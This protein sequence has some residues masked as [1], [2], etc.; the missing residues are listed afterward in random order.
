MVLNP[1]E[2]TRAI[3]TQL[4]ILRKIWNDKAAY[5]IWKAPLCE[6]ECSDNRISRSVAN[7]IQTLVF[8]AIDAPQLSLQPRSAGKL[9]ENGEIDEPRSN[10]ARFAFGVPKSVARN[11]Y[12][13][14]S[15]RKRANI[16]RIQQMD[17]ILAKT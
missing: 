3:F 16:L 17:I 15:I 11:M 4:H 8:L 1:M 9:L 6:L 14:I 13:S 5:T 10:I 7:K 12:P 2:Q